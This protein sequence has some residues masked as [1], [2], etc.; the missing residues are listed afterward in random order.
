M[1]HRWRWLIAVLALAAVAAA[2]PPGN[3][4]AKPD[5]EYTGLVKQVQQAQ[6]KASQAYEKAQGEQAKQKVLANYRAQLQE[7]TRRILAFAEKHPK[8]EHAF[9]ALSFVLQLVP[10]GPEADKAVALLAK[11]H[12][13]NP[14]AVELAEEL[15][16]ADSPEAETLV[17]ALLS[18]NRDAKA[19]DNLKLTLAD[20]LQSKAEKAGATQ[21]QK[22]EKE[23][24]DLVDQVAGSKDAVELAQT[25]AQA[26]GAVAEKLVR[27]ILARST[28]P[29]SKATLNL[30][31]AQVLK[32]RAEKSG[33]SAAEAKRLEEAAADLLGK[34]AGSKVADL[35][36]VAAQAKELLFALHHLSVGKVALNI[37][38]ED[39]DG[40]KF[41]LKD[42][43]GKVVLLD[44]WAS[45]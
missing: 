40:K 29:K 2:E 24:D 1:R 25:A 17:R 32:A 7:Y 42:Y 22:L 16:Q 36:D 5:A 4:P 38:G 18:R 6:A 26:G 15:A 23:V 31:L 43:Q 21:A 39:A 20:L 8:N 30:S 11:D 28:D 37:Q 3:K 34:L 45:W 27:A 41:K 35:K 19:Q 44:F 12:A 9:E 14:D 13:T 10:Q 33:V